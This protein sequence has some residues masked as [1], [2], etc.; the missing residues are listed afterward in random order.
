MLTVD[1][2]F[3]LACP[4]KEIQNGQPSGVLIHPPTPRAAFSSNSAR[5]RLVPLRKV[6]PGG[7]CGVHRRHHRLEGVLQTHP[8]TVRW[9]VVGGGW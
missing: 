2:S 8:V 1:S 4:C 7:R 3:Y 9:W 6:Q 5:R